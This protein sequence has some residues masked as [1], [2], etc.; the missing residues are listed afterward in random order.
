MARKYVLAN[1]PDGRSGILLNKDVSSD[2]AV[3]LWINAQ[4]PSPLIFYGDPTDGRELMHEPPD[5]GAIFRIVT[6]NRELNDITPEQM[7]E[8]HKALNSDHVPTLEELQTAKH[9]SMHKTDTLNYFV[10]LSG[11]L[12]MLSEEEDVLL[13]PGDFVVQMG[14]IHGWKVESEEP[15]VLACVLIDGVPEAS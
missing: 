14:G 8:M 3:D 9:P 7:L 10:L 2:G 6:F 4:T 12:W 15:A 11:K 5:G 13:E 1:R